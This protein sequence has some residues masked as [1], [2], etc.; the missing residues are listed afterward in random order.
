M[1]TEQVNHP[2]HYVALNLHGSVV[3][4]VKGRQLDL[5]FLA[6]NGI[7]KDYFTI[8]K[9][10]ITFSPI[11]TTE[12]MLPL[13]AFPNPAGANLTLLVPETERPPFS[14]TIRNMQ[15]IIVKKGSG[16][17]PKIEL[18]LGDYPAGFYL[19]EVQATKSSQQYLARIVVR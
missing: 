3:I 15:G 17:A 6:K 10:G 16:M 8:V 5:K 2:A 1:S 9:D 19:V 7:V 4:E 14:Y 12:E 11:T 18:E 13:K